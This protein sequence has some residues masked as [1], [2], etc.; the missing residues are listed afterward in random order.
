MV[1]KIL[2]LVAMATFTA[3]ADN[4]EFP[5]LAR[6]ITDYIDDSNPIIQKMNEALFG[7]SEQGPFECLGIVA[8]A[9]LFKDSLGLSQRDKAILIDKLNRGVP[10]E[11]VAKEAEKRYLH[12]FNLIYQ[13]YLYC[14]AEKASKE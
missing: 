9:A 7:W 5:S 11:Q 13:K 12:N 10:L 8:V 14:I 2:F 3:Q 4:D 1:K 6:K